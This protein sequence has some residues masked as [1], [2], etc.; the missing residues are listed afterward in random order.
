MSITS[1]V[2]LPPLAN[3]ER[4][5]EL[6]R[7]IEAG[8][9]AEYL[10]VTGSKHPP[11]QLRRVAQAGKQAWETLWLSNL[12]L[13]AKLSH[14]AARRHRLPLDDLFQDGCLGL[15]EALTRFDFALGWRF[16]T[17]A[18]EYVERA[19]KASAARR[20]GALEGPGRRHRLRILLKQEAGRVTAAE[21]REPPVREVAKL[22]GVSIAAAAGA[23]A[24]TTSLDEVGPRQVTSDGGFDAVEVTGLGFLALLGT[25]GD[26][27]RLRYGL[28]VRCHTQAEIGELL[29][30]SASTVARME[31]RALARAKSVLESDQCRLPGTGC[32]AG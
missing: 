31:R 16:S 23:W 6:A 32:P 2:F 21:H 18:H 24:V 29:G 19:L 10:L 17:L 13:V 7:R 4:E 30:V 22:V 14:A 20:S 11:A 15:A 28:G 1:A 8:V 12:R 9:Y 5:Y 3:V 25:G 26:L 27:L